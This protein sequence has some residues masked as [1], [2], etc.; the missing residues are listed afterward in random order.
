MNA[1]GKLRLAMQRLLGRYPLHGAI[2]AGWNPIADESVGTMAVAVE[3]AH[4]RLRAAPAFVESLELDELIGVLLHETNHVLGEHM[5]MGPE[6]Y[7]DRIALTI[8][9]EVTANEYIA[10]VLPGC[11]ILVEHFPDLPPDEDAHTRYKRLESQLDQDVETLDDHEAWE[12]LRQDPDLAKAIL[13]STVAVALQRLTPEQR[14]E[15]P[16]TLIL[17]AES[18]AGRA[19]TSTL[20]DGKSR[21]QVDW[22]AALRRYV[23]TVLSRRATYSRPPR[24]FPHLLGVVPGHS[25]QGAKPRVM[26]V[27][28]TSASLSPPM[29]SAISDELASMAKRYEVVVVECDNTIR[30]VYPFKPITS[31]QGRGGTDLR[32]PLKDEFLRKQR[33]DLVVYFTDGCGRAPQDAPRVP[34]LW[35]LTPAGRHPTSWGQVIRLPDLRGF[36]LH[37]IGPRRC[38]F[39]TPLPKTVHKPAI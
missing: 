38:D 31:V 9:T 24:R 13:G 28:D 21:A 3:G 14:A 37:K 22:R 26:A 1:L 27:M 17:Q 15:C 34:V 10:E 23:G 32:P 19:K 29:L 7:P 5:W 36:S 16:R 33:A 18:V 35:C 30:A 8:A 20:A 11:P 6:D 12:E 2:L 4:V 25:W 39:G